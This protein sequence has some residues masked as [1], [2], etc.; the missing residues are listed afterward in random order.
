MKDNSPAPEAA[1]PPN[2]IK[3]II[4]EDRRSNKNEGCVHTR[5]PPEPNG[6]LHI[7]HAKSICLN[8]GLAKEYGGK[9]NL[10]FDD[11][12]PATEEV[13]YVDSIMGDVRWLGFDWEDRL[14]YASDYFDRLYELALELV[15]AG[16]AYVCD[17]T[18][19]QVRETRGTLSE[20]GKESPGR[21]RSIE[22]NLDLFQRMKAGEFPDGKYTL[23]ARID[24]ASPNLNMRDPVMYR[25]KHAHHHRQ[26]DKWCIYPMYDYIH[27][28]SD[29]IEGV[30]HSICTLEFED[31]R[32]LYDWFLDE[33]KLKP[34]PQ[35]IEFARLN[36]TYTVLSKRKLLILVNNGHV[37]GWDDPR[38]PT[39]AG[40][41]RRGYTPEA[42]RMLCERVGVAKANSTVDVAL[43]DFCQREDLNK[44]A[45]RRMAVLKPL[46]VIIDNYPEGRTEEL[47]AE[48]N[49]EDPSAGKR[50]LPFSRELF[51]EEEDFAESP[52]P[53]YFRL[54]PGIE[55]RLKHAYYIKFDHVV[56]DPGTGKVL[57]VH[58]TYDPD[59]RGG[60]TSDGRVVKGTLHWLSAP[61]AKKAEVRLYDHL[62]TQPDPDDVPEGKD[63]LSC[64]NPNSL[65]VLPQTLVE[66]ALMQ[67]KPGDL[68]QFLRLGYFC[69]DPIDSKAGQPIFNRTVTL[70]DTWAKIEKKRDN[71]RSGR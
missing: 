39:I 1:L 52:P 66:P 8:F 19:D 22:E 14:F 20:P 40:L 62:F 70:R 54:A 4:D 47:E 44:R 60:G 64:L 2:F 21:K 16:K 9:C 24:M 67:A 15:R 38:L 3:D 69:V 27:G 61:H 56:K 18:Q 5:F 63:F 58:C 7:G 50:K 46:K 26:G 28:I 32:P 59:S 53:K 51:I 10:R 43:L 41:R 31:H 17:L 68:F 34:H 36:I 33:L 71:R 45:L 11:S 12:N 65:E 29:S 48:N 23:R 30:T 35:Q 49:P 25:I 13:E 57:E 6:Y 37:K 42:I 55:V